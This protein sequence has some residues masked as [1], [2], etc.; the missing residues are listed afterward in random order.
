MRQFILHCFADGSTEL[1][2]AEENK[3]D[4]VTEPATAPGGLSHSNSMNATAPAPSGGSA[5]NNLSQNAGDPAPT[6]P[7]G[8]ALNNLSQNT[9]A[10]ARGDSTTAAAEETAV[11]DE[12]DVETG[13]VSEGAGEGPDGLTVEESALADWTPAS[14]VDVTVRE[15][16][17]S[18]VRPFVGTTGTILGRAGNA[19]W[20]VQLKGHEG[21]VNFTKAELKKN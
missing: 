21:T 12:E 19:Y 2:N 17:R 14:M 9:T 20:K 4:D 3:A 7:G 18:S 15:N 5:L 16:V 11:P 10:P 6:A 13:S 8:S 1:D